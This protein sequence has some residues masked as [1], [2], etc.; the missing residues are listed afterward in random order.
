MKL[1]TDTKAQLD[2]FSGFLNY[3]VLTAIGL[4]MIL[5]FSPMLDML[6]DLFSGVYD[7]TFT[8]NAFY[9]AGINNN[10]LSAI[11][12]WYLL[13]TLMTVSALAFIVIVTIRKQGQSQERSRDF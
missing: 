2:I 10:L 8:E 6:T 13:I 12:G 4:V 11:S 5:A 3:V 7:P 9:T 1:I